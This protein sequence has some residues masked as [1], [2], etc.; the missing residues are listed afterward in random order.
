MKR[1]FFCH[2]GVGGV[3]SSPYFSRIALWWFCSVAC[4]VC[5][6]CTRLDMLP[7]RP[8]FRQTR[9]GAVGLGV[10]TARRA[11]RRR[12][13]VLQGKCCVCVSF[14]S[15]VLL[16]SSVLFPSAQHP[17]RDERVPASIAAVS[18]IPPPR[19][20]RSRHRSRSRFHAVP[21]PKLGLK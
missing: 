7:C 14:F 5:I 16:V 17:R 18:I 15:S 9:G 11:S 1:I 4:N 20:R 8:S 13:P 19:R 2:S 6:L 10:T 3:D 21:D 12:R